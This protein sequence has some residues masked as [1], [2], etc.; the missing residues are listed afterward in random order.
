MHT[1]SVIIPV[2]NA[3]EILKKSITSVLQQS[4]PNIEVILIDDGSTD[5]SSKICD[6]FAKE[7]QNVSAYHTSNQGSGPARNIGIS[8]ADGEF[9]YF[10]DA[11]DILPDGALQS[12]WDGTKGGHDLVVGGYCAVDDHGGTVFE[13][14]Y[15][16]GIY[17]GADLRRHYADCFNDEGALYI[18]GAPWNKLF[19]LTVI[20][21]N[22]VSF[23]PMKRHQ[24]EAFIGRYMCYA[25]SVHYIDK[26]V[27]RYLRN[28]MKRMWDKFPKNYFDI[29]MQLRRERESN[30]LLWNPDDTHTRDYADKE[31][32][33]NVIRAMELTFSPKYHYTRR[34]RKAAIQSMSEQSGILFMQIPNS[35]KWY[36]HTILTRCQHHQS[37]YGLLK[38][39]TWL[40]RT[41]ILEI[42]KYGI[43][44]RSLF[45]HRT[46]KSCKT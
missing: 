38:I 36:P 46:S 16:D 1:I 29:I 22:K 19:S 35:A 3:G 12:L 6:T 31:H 18:Q 2:Y 39:K 14:R 11:D 21:E 7:N 5:G 32:L 26:C 4:L 13:K 10:V 17:D 24:D 40:M 42:L 27:Y 34:Q 23:P 15:R 37:V 28:D 33:C 25:K 41:G 20:R 8:H 45:V 44:G 43:S 30:I 9:A